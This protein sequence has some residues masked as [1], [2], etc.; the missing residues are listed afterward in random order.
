MNGSVAERGMRWTLVGAA[1]VAAAAHVPG[2]EEHLH[3]APYMGVLFAAFTLA[4]AGVAAVVA[5]RPG[6]GAYAAAAGLCGAAVLTYAATR[7]V[8]FPQLAD[9]VGHWAEPLGVVSIATELLVV[10]CA[11]PLLRRTATQP[12]SR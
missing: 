10:A 1:L 11:L 5:T 3:E 7:L 12:V 8:A 9:D 6:R 4:C 2:I